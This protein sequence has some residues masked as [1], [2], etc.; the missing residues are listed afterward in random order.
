MAQPR[1]PHSICALIVLLCLSCGPDIAAARQ[2]SQVPSGSG[3][4]SATGGEQPSEIRPRPSTEVARAVDAAIRMGRFHEALG[5]LERGADPRI[6]TPNGN[7]PLI[8]AA[9]GGMIEVV[10]SLLQRRA[11]PNVRNSRGFSPLMMAAREGRTDIARALI[12]GGADRRLKNK[13]RETAAEI[14][15][16]AGHDAISKLLE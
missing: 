5:L 11:D 4:S 15:A 12:E 10:R 14:A 6:S 13:R 7:T 2:D 9:Q 16:V 1:L 8:L 3:Q